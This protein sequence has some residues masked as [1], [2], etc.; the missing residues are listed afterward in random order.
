MTGL[1][2]ATTAFSGVSFVAYGISCLVSSSMRL[3]FERF[4]L[5]RFRPLVG[6][7]ELM[8]GSAQLLAWLFYPL[9]LLGSG[10]L[11]CLMAMGVITRWRI[12]DRLWVTLPAIAY[13][14]IN[15]YLV[16]AFLNP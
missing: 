13:L 8:G 10:G 3:E 1:A 16:M 15:A 12:R 11:F 4:R 7:L 6:W 2:I 9:G 5:A 14:V